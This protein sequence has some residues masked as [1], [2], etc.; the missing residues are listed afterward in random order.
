MNL[1]IV[2]DSAQVRQII[3]VLLADIADQIHECANGA[4]AIVSY[5]LFH[6]DWI[7]MDIDMPVCDGIVATKRIKESSP[8]AR[9]I[10]ITAHNSLTLRQAAHDAGAC[11]Y[12]LKDDLNDVRTIIVSDKDANSESGGDKPNHFFSKQLNL[13]LQFLSSKYGAA[14]LSTE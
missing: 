14:N 7:L 1:L 12:V 11:G 4:E 3:K 13:F 5:G 6:Q 9:I 2:D 10:I 8:E